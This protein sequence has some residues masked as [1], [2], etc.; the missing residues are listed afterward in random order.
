MLLENLQSLNDYINR[1]IIKINRHVFDLEILFDN[2]EIVKLVLQDYI[3]NDN[4][5]VKLISNEKIVPFIKTSVFDINEPA[6]VDIRDYEN[7]VLLSAHIVDNILVLTTD[8]GELKVTSINSFNNVYDITNFTVLTN[9]PIEEV[10]VEESG[11]SINSPI[12]PL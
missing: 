11:E 4:I 7:S 10:I 8:K 2:D 12:I 5:R 1:N 3:Y 6:I 9:K